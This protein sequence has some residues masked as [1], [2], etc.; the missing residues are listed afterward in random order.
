MTRQHL[1][2]GACWCK[3]V[4]IF[5]AGNDYGKV[6]VH[7]SEGADL[8]EDPGTEAMMVAVF[9]ALYQEEEIHIKDYP[10]ELTYEHKLN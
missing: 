5:N 2:D 4:C 1:S 8:P 10:E 3:P 7:R 6:F 9:R